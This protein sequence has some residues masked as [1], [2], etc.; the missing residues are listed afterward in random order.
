VPVLFVVFILTAF[1]VT[2]TTASRRE[3]RSSGAFLKDT[4]AYFI[5]KGA[6]NYAAAALQ[7]GTNGGTVPPQLSAPPETDANGWTQLGDGW[8]K[9][10]LLDTTS[11]VNINT[12]TLDSISHLPGLLNTNIPACIVDWRDE[13]DTP[14]AGQAGTGAESDYY[15]ALNP[16]YSAKNQPFDTVEELL[17]VSG[18]TPSILYGAPGADPDTSGIQQNPA[19]PAGVSRQGGGQGGG[20]Q[21]GGGGGQGQPEDP[22]G[23]PV[24]TSGSIIPLSELVTTYSKE[25]N[26]DAE[27]VKRVNVASANEEA[28]Q[29]AGFPPQI[30]QRIVE[31][32]Q[33]TPIASVADLLNIPG[34]T[35]QIMQQVGDK[36]TVTDEQFRTGVININSASDEAMATIPGVDATVYNA[37]I[38]A[39]RGGMVFNGLNDLFQL[40]S[41]NRRQLQALVDH[42]C[43]KSSAYLVRVK[44]RMPGSRRVYAAQALVELSPPPDPAAEQSGQQAPQTEPQGPKILQWRE[45]PRTPGWS[46][47]APAPDLFG[48]GGAIGAR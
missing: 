37:V 25:L 34:V 33:Q 41:L 15:Q 32:R 3:T 6:V 18:L 35:R 21:G 46:S 9:I 7:E 48:T 13:D 4:Q 8:Y 10:E 1:A 38:E 22:A 14:T 39:R 5:A 27:G 31:T 12:A 26:V 11:R 42:V 2:V 30:A 47:W 16:P 40:T 19:S 36:L 20:G 44:V 29:T 23:P 24:D 17:L 45:V 43:T 28:L